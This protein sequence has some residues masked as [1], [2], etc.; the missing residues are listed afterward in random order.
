MALVALRSAMAVSMVVMAMAVIVMGVIMPAAA[1][2]TMGVVV[3]MRMGV[4]M[5]MAVVLVAVVVM[6]VIVMIVA[7]AAIIAMVVVHLRLRLERTL[8]RRHGAALPAHQLG[9][10][11]DV[12]DIKRVGRHLGRDVVAAEMPGEPHQP[13]RVFGADFQQAL[14]SG[15]DLHEPTILQLQS[16]AIVEHCGLVEVDGEFQ[17]ARRR[18]R[19]GAPA[20]IPMPEAERVDDALGADGG[21]ANDG[22]GAKH[23]R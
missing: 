1:A 16:I 7:A 21:L 13:Q 3:V 4:L 18:H 11:G 5:T 17:P 23:V 12:D 14:W 20:A 6:A 15:L 22:S 2:L 10:G 8:D 9:D 19:Q